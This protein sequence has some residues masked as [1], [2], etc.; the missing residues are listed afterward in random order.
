M[1][2]DVM[3]ENKHEK[4]IVKLTKESDLESLFEIKYFILVNILH[5]SVKQSSLSHKSGILL[6]VEDLLF[7]G[8][9]TGLTVDCLGFKNSLCLLDS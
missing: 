8:G 7:F 5:W 4:D 1:Y 2:R 6:S 3:K 9:V